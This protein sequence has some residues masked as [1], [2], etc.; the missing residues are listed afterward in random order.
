MWIP[1]SLEILC[2]CFPTKA[3]LGDILW[4]SGIREPLL[5]CGTSPASALGLLLWDFPILGLSFPICKM[6]GP[7]E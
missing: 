6:Q 3:L 4:D 7:V 5:M 1:L 2:P